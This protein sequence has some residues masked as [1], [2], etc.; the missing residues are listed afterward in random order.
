[1]AEEESALRLIDSAAC[2]TSSAVRDESREQGLDY[3]VLYRTAAGGSSGTPR[4]RPSSSARGSARGSRFRA[5]GL[6][7]PR[8]A[9]RGARL[10]RRGAAPGERRRGV[11]QE[12]PD[13]RG[14]PA[15]SEISSEIE[16]LPRCTGGSAST[17]G[18]R[19]GPLG[20][21]GD[22]VGGARPGELLL[23]A[24]VSRSIA[25]PILALE[26][27][28]AVSA[29]DLAHRVTPEGTR[30]VRYLGS[31]FNRMVEEIQSS[32]RALCAPSV[33]PLARGGAGGRARDQIRSPRSSSRAAASR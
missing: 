25:R 11:R 24:L 33:S 28:G 6:V 19:A 30:E 20:L 5:R 23:A 29:G 8:G 3:V 1:M 13:P 21:R 2:P 12:L 31:A 16:A 7:P 32:R 15:R 9:Q 17:R 27:D 22:L 4:S 10:G 14:L 18:F 26:R